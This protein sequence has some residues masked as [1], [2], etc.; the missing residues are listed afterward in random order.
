MMPWSSVP[1]RNSAAEDGYSDTLV[2]TIRRIASPA[3]VA[4][5]GVNGLGLSEAP[6]T[7]GPAAP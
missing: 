3:Q 5:N 1:G 6:R 2:V 4:T 7:P